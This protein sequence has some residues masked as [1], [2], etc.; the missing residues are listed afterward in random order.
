SRHRSQDMGQPLTRGPQASGLELA[1]SRAASAGGAGASLFAGM[2]TTLSALAAGGGDGGGAAAAHLLH[3]YERRIHEVRAAFN[4]LDPS[5]MVPALGAALR[6]LREAAAAVPAG[7]LAEEIRREEG[8]AV[9][10]LWRAAGLDL[11]VVAER[12]TVV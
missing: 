7:E 8:D 10:A 3:D 9:A 4:P 6:V 12:E 11:D 5:A 2:D 1:A